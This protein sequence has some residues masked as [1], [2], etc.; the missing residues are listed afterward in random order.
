MGKQ[1]REGLRALREQRRAFAAFWSVMRSSMLS[2][3]PPKRKKSASKVKAETH[4]QN[5]A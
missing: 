2:S 1:Y 4:G 5:T 3:R